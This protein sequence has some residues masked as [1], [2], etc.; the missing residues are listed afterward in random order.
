MQKIY[1]DNA[2]TSFPKPRQVSDA[3]YDYMT[4]IGS[5]IN[6]GCYRDAYSAEEMVFDT[7]R[8]L[9]ELFRGEDLKNVIF[10]KNVTE[11]LNVI[12]RGFL[13][14]GD[15]VLVSSMEHNAV[16]RPLVQLQASGVSFSR[17]PCS[18][19]GSLLTEA[20]EEYLEENTRALV[21]THA[22]NVCGTMMPLKEAGEFCRK[23][24]IAFIVDAAQT[25]GVFPVDMEE[26]AIDAL[27]FTGHKGL[28]GPQGT[29]GFLL[30][31]D[32]IR[33]VGPLICGGTGSLSHTEETP[34]FMPDRY[35]AGTMNLPGIAGL[36]ASLLFLKETGIDRIRQHE[37]LLTERFLNGLDKLEEE[38]R[39]RV[40]GKKDTN[41][42]TGVVSIQT[43]SLDQAEAS[44][45]LE[46]QYG[47]LTRVGLHCA[48]S[49]HKTLGT[50]PTGTIR[51]SF[52][53][54]NT[55]ADVDAALSA[56]E[57]LTRGRA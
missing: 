53:F 13:R 39:I 23:H 4:R 2:C 42:R 10:T 14:R 6:R 3:V 38:G 32:M 28:L 11:S 7:R 55:Q 20:M 31:E 27:A 17:I 45:L 29:G 50:Y 9:C 44:V 57:E 19:D 26:Y 12:L 21:L 8:M 15:H 5:N 48:P 43:L 16:M 49:A 41:S 37:L 46:E 34:S 52:G 30:K 51:F 24:G 1:L 47:I 40:S 56:L 18:P 36:H 22:S 33:Q 54:Y 25:A 35:E